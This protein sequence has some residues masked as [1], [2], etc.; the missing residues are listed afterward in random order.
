M[1]AI[2]QK[3]DLKNIDRS[4]WKSYRFDTI[5]KNVS[6]RVDPNNTELETYVGLEHIDSESLHIKR[7]GTR[8]DVNGTKLR[9]YPGDIIFGRRR[10]YQRKAGIATFNGFCSAHSLVLRANPTIIHPKLFPFFIHSDVFMNRAVDIS[11]GSLSPTINWGTLKTQEFQLPPKEQQEQLA[12]L[13]WAM[14]D[15]LQEERRL[16]DKMEILLSS[17]YEKFKKTNPNWGKYKIKDLLAFHYGKALK[18]S[19]RI[20]GDYAV[21]SSSGIQG[22]HCEYLTE[23]PGIVVGRKGNVGEVTWI[24]GGF[25]TTDTAYYVTVNENFKH[26][27]LKFFYHLLL[28]AN[29]KQYSIATAVP[30][31]NRDDALLTNI[32]LP[33][34]DEISEYLNKFENI[35]ERI[36]MIKHKLSISKSLQKSLINQ[37]FG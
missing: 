34:E 1:E 18:E 31:L 30:G 10:A 36:E 21:V 3:V 5:A 26:I 14:D 4:K 28:S 23:G 33:S 12:E 19:D 32:F 9:C 35:G 24:K 25:W 37:I 11:V 7:T 17:L 29:L 16:L 27:P 8:D 22:S 20:E 2:L 6:E 13:L 15:V